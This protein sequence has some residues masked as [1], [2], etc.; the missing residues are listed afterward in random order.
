MQEPNRRRAAVVY[1]SFGA[2]V[3]LVCTVCAALPADARDLGGDAAGNPSLLWNTFVGGGDR[4]A[5]WSIGRDSAGNIY[6]GGTSH[7]SWGSPLRLY[8]SLNDAYVAKFS[9]DG[10]L[11][12]NA[13]LGGNG[14]DTCDGIAVDGSGNVY[15]VGDSGGTWG[16]PIRGYGAQTDIFVAMLSTNGAL[17][18]NTF[19]GGGSQDY[20]ISIALAG[21]GDICVL[22]ECFGHW[23]TPAPAA[24]TGN[25]CVARLNAGGG[26]SWHTFLG[27]SES[28]D[29]S[30][31]IAVGPSGDIFVSGYGDAT[32]GSPVWP[33]SGG[34]DGFLAKLSSAG[35]LLWNTFLGGSG[36]DIPW[37]MVVDALETIYLDGI[38]G[39]T[40]GAP[41]R[42]HTAANDVFAAKFHSNGLLL[43]NTFL[44]GDTAEY[45]NGIAVDA[46]G[47]SYV[48][49]TSK[50][51]W[52][53][54]IQAFTSGEDGFVAKLDGNG[55]LLWNT[56]VGGGG[57]DYAADIT[58]DSGGDAFV[59]G[60]STSSWGSPLTPFAGGTH[61]GFVARL[62]E[63][64]ASAV[65]ITSITS[66]TSKPGSTATIRGTGFST[67]KTKNVV[68]FGTKKATVNRA[69]ATSLTVTIPRVQKGTVDVYVVV[70]GEKSNTLKF[71]VK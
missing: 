9:S 64:A 29:G 55:S 34:T 60:T 38:S 17:L 66:R 67:T 19:L 63:S 49:G 22:G 52:G 61:D 54:P 15:V 37:R 56:F 21:T 33:H 50:G 3:V 4:D 39:A 10:S 20:G 69:K 53:A 25:V 46:S 44:G 43:W 70:N 57:D 32:W 16:L 48:V 27:T 24:M 7:G 41:I 13:F 62:H 6:V 18:W 26:L 30:S 11:L 45:A 40:W 68:Y 36:R 47:N 12:W 31:D 1:R 8:S 2:F 59:V 51:T 42:A 5:G 35:A 71:Q 58:L 65:T 23:G 14:D 28:E